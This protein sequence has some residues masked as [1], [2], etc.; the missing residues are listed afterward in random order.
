MQ[1][2]NDQPIKKVLL[3]WV[4][5]NRMKG[6]LTQVKIKRL[7][8]SMMGPSIASYTKDILI[9]K[10]KMYITIISAPLKQELS[11]GKEKIRKMINEEL[12]EDYIQEVI[13]R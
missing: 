12:G 3:E 2:K 6:K 1:E 13:I 11:Y 10:H 7:W 9:R 5:K 4:Q 8:E